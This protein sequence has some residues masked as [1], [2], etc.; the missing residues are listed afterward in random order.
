M[1]SNKAL[2]VVESF[3][4]DGPMIPRFPPVPGSDSLRRRI[5]GFPLA[6]LLAVELPGTLVTARLAW[7]WVADPLTLGRHFGWADTKAQPGFLPYSL[8]PDDCKALSE[9]IP[10]VEAAW[11]AKIDIAVRR[12]LS[13]AHARTD[14][15]DRLVDAVIAWENMFGTSEGEPRL[16]ITAAM[17]WLLEDQAVAREA[18]Q[19]KLKGLYDDRSKIVHGGQF[20]PASIPERADDALLFAL[21]S[22]RVLFRDRPDVLDLPDGSARSLRLILGS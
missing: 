18:L 1:T 9:W 15:V 7:Y 11:T 21:R 12:I 22:L 14:P 8:S 10:R 19:R 17:A 5:E 13:A 3:P 2:L 4:S 6:A 16:R 20:D